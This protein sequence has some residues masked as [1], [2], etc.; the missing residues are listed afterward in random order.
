MTNRRESIF[1][2]EERVLPKH[3]RSTC[4]FGSFIPRPSPMARQPPTRHCSRAPLSVRSI[5]GSCTLI[6]ASSMLTE[7]RTMDGLCLLAPQGPGG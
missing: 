7:G 1:M 4:H 5:G 6:S 3:A 2:Q